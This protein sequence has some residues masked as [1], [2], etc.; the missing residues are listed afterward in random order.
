MLWRGQLSGVVV[1]FT[2]S[3]LAAW[4]SPVWILGVDLA[5]LIKPCCGSIPQRRARRTYNQDIQIYTGD[6]VRK[7]KEEDWQ[8]MLAQGQSSFKKKKEKPKKRLK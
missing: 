3:A 2:C 8:W 5:P 4:G 6:L 7:K 1:K